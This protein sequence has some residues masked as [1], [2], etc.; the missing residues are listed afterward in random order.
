MDETRTDVTDGVVCPAC[1]GDGL[2][3]GPP[4]RAEDRAFVGCV[5]AV[6]PGYPAVGHIQACLPYGSCQGHI[7]VPSSPEISKFTVM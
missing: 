2:V 1:V 7:T 4:G 5:S 3:P 6:L